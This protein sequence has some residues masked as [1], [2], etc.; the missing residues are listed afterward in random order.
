M[1]QMLARLRDFFPEPANA[2]ARERVLSATGAFAGILAT[3]LVSHAAVGEASSLPVMVAPMG[4]SAVLLFAVPSSPLA[5]PWSIAGGNLVAALVGVTAARFIGNPYLAAAIAISVAIALM[6]ALRCLHPPS[7]AVA[8]T[9][10]LGGH[11]ITDLGYGF[12]LW[13]VMANSLLLLT[14]ALLF[15]NLAGRAYPKPRPQPAVDHKTADPSPPARVGVTSSDLDAALK[16]YGQF[17]DIGRGDLETILRNA[18]RR[19]L[20]RQAG[21][22]MVADIMTRDV[23]AIA[24]EAP[25]AEALKLLR[26][27]HIK[28]LP[29]TDESARVVGIVTQT[30]LLDKADWNGRGPHI[31]FRQRVRLTMSRVRAPHGVVDDIMTTPVTTVEPGA[32]VVDVVLRMTDAGVHHLPVVSPDGQLAGVVS[33]TDVIAALLNDIGRRDG[34]STEPSP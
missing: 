14:S 34:P 10:V 28:M 18:Q 8:L 9:A 15:N 25:L 29:V 5:Q 6:M 2:S 1:T 4:A 32:S 19:S 11:A 20:S 22:T 33:Q 23:I 30:D 12:V 21:R 7:G 16:D 13:P 3:G 31:G 17:L 24:P 26:R 27:H